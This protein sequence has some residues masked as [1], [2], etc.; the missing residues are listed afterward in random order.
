MA[1][2]QAPGTALDRYQRADD[3]FPI[4][5]SEAR[6]PELHNLPLPLHWQ[7]KL[8]ELLPHLRRVRNAAL[9][10]VRKRADVALRAAQNNPESL[11][12]ALHHISRKGLQI[13]LDRALIRF[14]QAPPQL[15]EHAR[16]GVLGVIEK[17]LARITVNAVAE[18]F[19][20]NHCFD[21]WQDFLQRAFPDDYP[22][23]KLSTPKW[24]RTRQ[25]DDT[26]ATLHSCLLGHLGEQWS[27][28]AYP[29]LTIAELW[30]AADRA[31]NQVAYLKEAARDHGEKC[32][33]STYAANLL[34]AGFAEKLNEK[35]FQE[36]RSGER[37]V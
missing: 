4:T 21:N 36:W 25:L 6:L 7:A 3:G 20:A 18:K 29:F 8:P 24:H 32:D 11:E 9:A 30:H 34:G 13:L 37:A 28:E 14:L 1:I 27:N 15:A 12:D 33:V 22:I 26:L 5:G 16:G 31:M 10:K 2:S 17:Y 19:A 23:S 35:R